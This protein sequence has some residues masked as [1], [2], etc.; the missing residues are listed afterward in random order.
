MP[1]FVARRLGSQGWF[2][3]WGAGAARGRAGRTRAPIARR[4]RAG[5]GALAIAVVG[6][7]STPAPADAASIFQ[8][9][10][11]HCNTLHVG[12]K[13]FPAGTVMHWSVSQQARTLATG[14]F[15]TAPGPGLHFY[16]VKLATPLDPHPKGSVTFVASVNG[17]EFQMTAGRAPANP[18][19]PLCP[20]AR[21]TRS[22]NPIP[23]RL[24]KAT[25]PATTRPAR[26]TLALT[27]NGPGALAGVVFVLTGA[28]LLLVAQPTARRARA[29]PGRI[30]APWLYVTPAPE[31]PNTTG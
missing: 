2:T 25:N 16:D 3:G 5:L 17:Q 30:P 21:V 11:R 9:E 23:A 27:G 14:H 4:A 6:V 31:R 29:R 13:H 26:P 10:F 7:V 20:T 22:G 12:Y 19:K 8:I 15:V 1:R 28:A 24:T 18:N